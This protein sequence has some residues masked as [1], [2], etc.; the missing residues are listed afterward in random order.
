M[1]ELGVERGIEEWLSFKQSGAV[2][3]TGVPPRQKQRVY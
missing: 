2:G 1:A 3:N